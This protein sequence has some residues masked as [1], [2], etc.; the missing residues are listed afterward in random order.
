[1]NQKHFDL[2]P[3]RSYSKVKKPVQAGKISA[4]KIVKVIRRSENSFGII[5][6]ITDKVPSAGSFFK[7]S[8]RNFSHY[9]IM[10]IFGVVVAVGVMS[11]P[12]TEKEKQNPF[13]LKEFGQE[14]NEVTYIQSVATIA[15]VID[16]E[17]GQKAYEVAIKQ[18][19]PVLAIASGDFLVKPVLAETRAGDRP[20]N[21]VQEYM[22]QDGDTLWSIAR[23]FDLTTDS[24]RWAN[25]IEDEDYVKPGDKLTVPPTVG[26]LHTVV[27]GDTLERIA[28]K[29]SSSVSLIISQNDL[30]GENL[31]IG[32]KVMVPDGFI[33][34]APKPQPVQRNIVGSGGY[35]P[36]AVNYSRSSYNSFPYGYCT[37]YVA[38]RRNVPWNGNAWQWYGNAIASGYAV[39]NVP[40]PGAI[41]VTWESGV[42]H[43]ALVESV[44]GGSFTISE[45]NYAGWGIQSSRT[46]TTSSVPLIG[47]IY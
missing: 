25:N 47:F 30:Y 37:W 15:S 40:S 24:L 22:V 45:M 18:D 39:G 32:M 2:K 35:T 1:M 21:D 23:N 43:V 28:N 19:L 20:K 41:M 34:E 3:N 16:T 6:K 26:V 44:S 33:P 4:K 17:L 5:L 38:S 9:I 12:N 42:G 27:E 36:P 11:N 29:Y 8:T 31:T 46:V 13:V 10:I 7:R 14:I